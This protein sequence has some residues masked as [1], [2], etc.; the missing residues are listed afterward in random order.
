[1]DTVGCGETKR[2]LESNSK[3]RTKRYFD[4]T[5][6]T[7]NRS[8][9]TIDNGWVSR[10]FGRD[11]LYTRRLEKV[12]HGDLLTNPEQPRQGRW[13]STQL[14]RQ[15]LEAG[16]VFEPLLVEPTLEGHGGA[17][18]RIIDGHRRW[19]NTGR[20]LKDLEG[21]RKKA[22]SD[23]AWQREYD[24][25]NL[26]NIEVTN[27]P[28]TLHER[29][30]IWVH[31]HRQRKDWDLKEKER[32][33]YR[34]L[35]VMSQAEAAMVLGVSVKE[36]V[37][38]VTIYEFSERLD[39][40]LAS[41]DA[42]ITWGREIGSLAAKYR[43]DELVDLVKDKIDKSLMVNSKEVRGLRDL[44]NHP[45]I[46]KK[47]KEQP[48][49][50]KEALDEIAGSKNPV[51]DFSRVGVPLPT[52]YAPSTNGF[53]SGLSH[54]LESFNAQLSRYSWTELA[55]LKKDPYFVAA[56]AEAKRKITELDEALNS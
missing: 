46:L 12:P 56:V 49:T 35:E 9:F 50:M 25:Y 2:G 6:N 15:I 11:V 24:K 43:S 44:V 4:M 14:E 22:E 48:I 18:Y 26:L 20:I 40:V 3:P 5:D 34:L 27:R 47:F 55:A 31:I 45:E 19:T 41:P 42:A 10:P 30:R 54:D 53:G 8:E 29:L 38:L 7:N 37:K 51:P 17:K 39:P 16:G 23:E 36:L 1:M 21:K 52:T 32:T 13:E 33:A 28:L